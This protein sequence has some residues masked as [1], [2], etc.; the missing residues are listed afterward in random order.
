MNAVA[1]QTDWGDKVGAAIV[2]GG[3]MPQVEMPTKHHFLPGLYLREIFMPAGTIVI[4]KIHRTEHFNIIQQGSVTLL[5]DGTCQRLTAPCTFV[6]KPGVQKVLY[7]HEDCVWT[8]VHQTQETTMEALE[9]E[10]IEPSADYPTFN[11]TAEQQAIE[12]AARE[13]AVLEHKS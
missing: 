7:I 4:G 13:A 1:Q 9:A 2:A 11:R 10:I 5:G 6:S 12:L 8:T 3:Q